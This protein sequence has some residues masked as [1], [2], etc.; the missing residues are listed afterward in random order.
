MVPDSST[1]VFTAA[2]CPNARVPTQQKRGETT[3]PLPISVLFVWPIDLRFQPTPEQERA[4]KELL[5]K[6]VGE[7]GDVDCDD[8]PEVVLHQADADPYAGRFVIRTCNVGQLLSDDML[9][10]IGT[11]LGCQVK[12]GL[13]GEPVTEKGESGEQ[14]ET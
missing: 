6:A 7:D 13:I 14:A 1:N 2:Y 8:H 3:V 5:Q 11:A 4:A 10:A 9:K 12:Q